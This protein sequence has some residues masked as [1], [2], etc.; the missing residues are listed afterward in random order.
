MMTIATETK[1]DVLCEACCSVLC[2][3]ILLLAHGMRALVRT[4][5]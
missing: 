5:P 2:V 1:Q 4:V 3:G